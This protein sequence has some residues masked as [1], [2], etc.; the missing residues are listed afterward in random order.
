MKEDDILKC[1]IALILGFLVAKYFR[2]EGFSPE[3]VA[4]TSLSDMNSRGCCISNT[5]GYSYNPV[6]VSGNIFQKIKLKIKGKIKS[7]NKFDFDY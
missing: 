5:A 4:S 7:E 3:V 6:S 1:F 2:M